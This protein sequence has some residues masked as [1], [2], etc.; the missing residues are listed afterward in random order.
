M[1]LQFHMEFNRAVE[2]C[3]NSYLFRS[4][5]LLQNFSRFCVFCFCQKGFCWPVSREIWWKTGM[6]DCPGIILL[7]LV[8]WSPHFPVQLLL[9]PMIAQCFGCSKHSCDH[10][11][12]FPPC[13][14]SYSRSDID[15]SQDGQ[16]LSVFVLSSCK[17]DLFD[18]GIFGW[19]CVRALHLHRTLALRNART[20]SDW[21][22][23]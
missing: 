5:I 22:G 10:W 14:V 2:V 19:P 18:A 20:F 11:D 12:F 3:L 6:P 16:S 1:V 7:W 8:P 13:F 21:L 23:K 4:L 9:I 15:S 17:A